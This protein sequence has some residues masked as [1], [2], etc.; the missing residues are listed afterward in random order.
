M[1]EHRPWSQRAV[2]A[3]ADTPDFSAVHRIE[4]G[5]RARAGNHNLRATC[6]GDEEWCAEGKLHLRRKI[7][8]YFPQGFSGECVERHDEG[9]GCALGD[10]DQ[11]ITGQNRRAAVAGDRVEAESVVAPDN[12]TRAVEA[13][14]PVVTEVNVEPLAVHEGS[15]T[16]GGVDLMQRLRGRAGR[17][18]HLGVPRDASSRG[19][20]AED[21]E[22]GGQLAPRHGGGR[23]KNLPVTHD[24]GRPAGAGHR[25]FPTDIVRGRPLERQS[26]GGAQTLPARTAKLGPVPGRRRSGEGGDRRETEESE[27][28]QFLH[29][30][31]L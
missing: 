24:G 12:F 26:H 20:E 15:R 2:S 8:R 16:R 27:G 14:G 11:A 7:T 21:V 22:P 25:L 13:G 4:G 17:G 5:D 31:V 29:A 23:Q 19:V 30:A 6:D 18:E 1:G 28:E 9:R 3:V 10:I